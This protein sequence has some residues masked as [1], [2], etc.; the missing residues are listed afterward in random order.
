MWQA[1]YCAKDS[2]WNRVEKTFRDRD[3][4]ILELM[5]RMN[6]CNE[7]GWRKEH[8]RGKALPQQTTRSCHLLSII[9]T[10]GFVTTMAPGCTLFNNARSSMSGSGFMSE[11]M[12]SLRDS[13]WAKRAYYRQRESGMQCGVHESSFKR[14]F[15]DGYRSVASGGTG[16]TPIVPPSEFWGWKY[17]SAEGQA[18]INAWFEGYPQGVA[19]AEADGIGSFN[20]I[21]LASLDQLKPKPFGD[22]GLGGPDSAAPPIVPNPNKTEPLPVP[23]QLDSQSRSTG[24]ILPAVAPA[25]ALAPIAEP[26][27]LQLPTGEQSIGTKLDE[28]SDMVVPKVGSEPVRE[29]NSK[30]LSMPLPASRALVY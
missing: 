3:Y 24:R 18:K 30:Q 12:T 6:E 26:A 20:K 5:Q 7:N 11:N 15:I 23:I 17:Q 27:K 21:Q 4:R 25:T 9:L 19:A 2:H 14:G 1:N 16:C 8:P 13:I 22:P 29:S 28:G 10:L